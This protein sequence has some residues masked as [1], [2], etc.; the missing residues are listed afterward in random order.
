MVPCHDSMSSVSAFYSPLILMNCG[1]LNVVGSKVEF[2]LLWK[3]SGSG[4]MVQAT[5]EERPPFVQRFVQPHW[6]YLGV[7]TQSEDI[8]ALMLHKWQQ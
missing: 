4:E 6:D 8:G 2:F 7:D 3:V 5:E 1:R